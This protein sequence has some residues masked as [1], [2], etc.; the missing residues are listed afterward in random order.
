MPHYLV[1]R[2]KEYRPDELG[3]P[4]PR[5]KGVEYAEGFSLE[6]AVSPDKAVEQA[7]RNQTGSYAVAEVE[8]REVGTVVINPDKN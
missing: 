3:R 4:S 1:T 8:L 6:F 7:A 2:L 5:Q